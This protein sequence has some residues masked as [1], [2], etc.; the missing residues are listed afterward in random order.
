MVGKVILLSTIFDAIFVYKKLI[1][2]YWS[3]DDANIVV[4]WVSHLPSIQMARELILYLL[5]KRF[6]HKCT[7]VLVLCNLIR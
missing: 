7:I 2:L 6:H 4:Q 5:N 1:I 3:F